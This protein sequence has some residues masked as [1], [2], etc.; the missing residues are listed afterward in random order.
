MGKI[1]EQILHQIYTMGKRIKPT[2]GAGQM[3]IENTFSSVGCLRDRSL[4]QK[5]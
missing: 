3:N 4:K 2:S 1:L 5:S